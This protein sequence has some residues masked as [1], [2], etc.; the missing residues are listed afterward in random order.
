MILIQLLGTSYIY[1]MKHIWFCLLFCGLLPF[2]TFSQGTPEA[3][4]P[5]AA[6]IRGIFEAALTQSDCYENLRTLCKKVPPRLS[7]SPGAAKA[8]EWG[9]KVMEATGLDSVWLQEVMVPHWERGKAEVAY[10]K[11]KQGKSTVPVCAL[12]GSIATPKKGIKAQVV[13]VQ[14]LRE[15]EKLGREKLQGKIVFYNRPMEA[16]LLNTFHAYGGCVDQRSQGAIEASKFGAL[17]VVVR[18]M[19]LRIDDYPH[20][21][22]MRYNPELDSIP[23]CAISTRGAEMLSKRLKEDPNL[24]FSLKMNCKWFPMAP[25]HNV[26]GEL[27]GSEFPDEIIVVGGHLD[28]W[29]LAEGAHDD[30]AGVVQSLEVLNLFKKT[31]YRPKRTVRAVFY[32]NEENGMRGALKYAEIAKK[33][34][35]NH[36]AGIESDRGGFTPRGFSVDG[37]QEVLELIQSWGK[38]LKPYFLH[39]LKPGYGGVDIG[40]LKKQ[41]AALFGF[42]PDSQRYFDYHHASNDVFEAVNKRE[43]ELGAASMAALIYLISEHGLPEH[44]VRQD[45]HQH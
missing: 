35:E 30:G 42:L 6:L 45:A 26:I 37:S 22:N 15:L 19:N 24:E 8:V 44:R 36:I 10:F 34:Q 4:D 14:N 33:N 3:A 18:S 23:A 17:A 13:E 20:T 11:D 32:M 43:L 27:K 38:F 5:E 25:S 29:D 12:G 31:G 39:D 9:Q 41:G 21:G 28:A 16:R 7:G 1:S 40:P 2:H